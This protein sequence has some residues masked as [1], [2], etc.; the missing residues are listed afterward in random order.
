MDEQSQ[1]SRGTPK[2]SM[3]HIVAWGLLALA[4]AALFCWRVATTDPRWRAQPATPAPDV[5]DR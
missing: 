3:T 4:L 5:Q 1:D 2:G